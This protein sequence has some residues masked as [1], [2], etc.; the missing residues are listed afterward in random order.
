MGS[1]MWDIF[2]NHKSQITDFK[3]QIS[4]VKN[5]GKKSNDTDKASG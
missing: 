5:N 1:E 2:L 4:G 3:S